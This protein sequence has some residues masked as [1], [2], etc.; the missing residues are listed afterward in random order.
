MNDTSGI[1]P[2]FGS[3]RWGSG[4]FLD[5]GP[6]ALPRAAV[7]CPVG[8]RDESM[9]RGHAG[10]VHSN[11]RGRAGIVFS[12]CRGRAGT[13]ALPFATVGCPVGANA[14][15]PKGA[16]YDSPGQRPGIRHPHFSQALN[17]RPI[18]SAN[19]A[20]YA[21]LGHR[22]GSLIPHIS[23]ALK[24]RSMVSLRGN[25]HGW[26]AHS[27]LDSLLNPV[28]G[29]LPRA[30]VECPVGALENN[31]SSANGETYASPGHRPGSLIPHISQA[32]KGRPI[33]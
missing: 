17:G 14:L 8:A 7:D 13:R 2:R 24:G 6:G 15:C 3:P 18:F 19:G 30:V 27:G 21:S 31:I 28:P 9:R 1:D 16:S 22:P 10:I 5:S 4:V 12:N 25:V 32:L 23:Q 20:T 29:A 33:R 26:N 11:N